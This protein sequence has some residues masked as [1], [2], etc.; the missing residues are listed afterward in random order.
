M[1]LRDLTEL[2]VTS[3]WSIVWTS[4]KTNSVDNIPTAGEGD[5]FLSRKERECK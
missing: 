5:I 1:D 2:A 4:Y 3:H